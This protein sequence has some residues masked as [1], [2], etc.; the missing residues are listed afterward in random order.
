[1]ISSYGFLAYALLQI[2]TICVL[3]VALCDIARRAFGLDQLLSTCA[4]V[5]M[6]GLLGYLSFW[7]AYANYR[8]FGVAKIAVLAGLLI[9]FGLVVYQRRINDYRWLAEPLLY[10]SLFC[11][12]VLALGGADGGTSMTSLTAE[13]RF[14]H[15]LPGDNLISWFVAAALRFGEAPTSRLGDWLLSDRP[16]LQTGLYLLLGLRS[17]L[18]AYQVVAAWLQA[19][20]LLGVWGIA[21]GAMLPTGA[22]RIV[23]LACCLL[24]TAIINT[25][26]VWPKLL[27][28][29]YVLFVF[30]LLFCRKPGSD[31]ER[32]AFG[33][34]IGALAALAML[35]H[36]SSLF[37]LIGFGIVALTFRAWPPLKT[38]IHGAATL[39]AIYTPWAVY[40]NFI[41]PPGNRLLKWHFAGVEAIDDRSFLQALRD[42]Y[43]AL[44]W[45]EYWRGKQENLQAL[46]DA[47]P[48]GL[49]D[50]LVGPFT[51]DWSPAA[52]RK[53]DF[54]ALLPSLHLF[55][56]AVV[57]ALALLVLVPCRQRAVGLKM[58]VAI[59]GTLAAFVLLV[60]T[61]GQTINH[62][63]TYAV[64]ILATILAFMVLMLR[65]PWLALAFVA[66]QAV[67]VS[68]T[69]GF[70]LSHDPASW[71]LLVACG[72]AALVLAGYSLAPQLLR[73]G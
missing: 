50:P 26:Y 18:V 19:G 52:V 41:E 15:T 64:Q 4:A 67:T 3:F 36:G 14:T 38:M 12:A 51:G 53:A 65:V 33:V 30:A 37:A 70:S 66:A 69:Y 16:P 40:Q 72:V 34:L 55:S 5:V 31:A 61:P 73:T 71:P 10:A 23:L 7:L 29:G 59:L 21:F 56:I 20:F 22:R 13:R 8:V 48:R 28:A 45:S 47:W 62:Q 44:S 39:L 35:S 1:M 32:K 46:W 68:V 58:L 9:R 24:P 63:G 60:F 42:S 27:S 25:Y 54:F 43:G 2:V 6:L 57:T 49:L 11:I 17:H